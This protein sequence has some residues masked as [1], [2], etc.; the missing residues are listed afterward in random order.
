[1]KGK[2]KIKFSRKGDIFSIDAV[3]KIDGKTI[4]PGT[5]AFI[6]EEEPKKKDA[7]AKKEAKTQDKASQ[8]QIESK[9]RSEILDGKKAVKKVAGKKVAVKNDG[10][11]DDEESCTGNYMTDHLKEQEKLSRKTLDDLLDKQR[12]LQKQM[13]QI[14]GEFPGVEKQR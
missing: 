5:S 6:P 8:K 14:D 9:L 12:E 3:I 7:P 11:K 4:R 13:S 1:M 2:I 10:K